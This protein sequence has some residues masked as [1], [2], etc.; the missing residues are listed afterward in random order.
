[1]LYL[2]DL[3]G[4]LIS[5]YMDS[6][7]KH[8]DAW[9]V[10][11]ERRA[12]LQGLMMQGHTVAIVTN[13]G[14]VAFGFVTEE[15]CYNKMDEAVGRLGLSVQSVRASGT[16]PPPI[17]YCCMHDERGKPPYNDP[18]EALRRKPNP[19]MLLEAMNDHGHAAN[20]GVLYVGDRAEDEAAAGE[21]AVHFEWASDFFNDPSQCR[22]C[23]NTPVLA[24]GVCAACNHNKLSRDGLMPV[25]WAARKTMETP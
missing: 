21:A 3:D 7:T 25:G 24:G 8:Y 5:G 18:G 4:T 11:P 14:G 13:Q 10:L 15:Q 17:V 6:P 9:Y 22:Q 23:G 2:F 19:F 12:K 20:K 1:M 16:T